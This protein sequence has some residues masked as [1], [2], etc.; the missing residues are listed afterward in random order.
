MRPGERGRRTGIEIDKGLLL[1]RRA[2]G[3]FGGGAGGDLLNDPALGLDVAEVLVEPFPL[4]LLIG[5]STFNVLVERSLS[6]PSAEHTIRPATS[7]LHL[8]MS[9]SA[10]GEVWTCLR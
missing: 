10:W 9:V 8:L 5:S 1:G 7:I 6:K 2:A 3:A 4:G